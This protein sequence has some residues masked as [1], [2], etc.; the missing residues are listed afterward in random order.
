MSD[1][2]KSYTTAFVET[3]KRNET[4]NKIVKLKKNK[5]LWIWM[6]DKTGVL[7]SEKKGSKVDKK[8]NRANERGYGY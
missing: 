5:K 7:I 8:S 2:I 4:T 3:V 1:V 6:F